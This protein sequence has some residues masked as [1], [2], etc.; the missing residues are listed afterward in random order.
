MI[1]TFLTA[2]LML[3]CSFALAQEKVVTHFFKEVNSSIAI[4]EGKANIQASQYRVVDIDIN[5]LYAELENAP[6]RDGISTGISLQF[7]LPQPDGTV[8]RYQV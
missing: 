1:R 8:K 2:F 7:E 6:H 5:Q 3:F 4:S